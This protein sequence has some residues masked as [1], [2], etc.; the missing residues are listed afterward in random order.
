MRR[1][2]IAELGLGE[3][4]VTGDWK[5]KLLAMAF[6][7]S[8]SAWF[9]KRGYSMMGW[10]VVRRIAGAKGGAADLQVEFFDMFTD[11]PTQNS[12]AVLTSLLVLLEA[13]QGDTR[14]GMGVNAVKIHVDQA[15]CFAG[16]FS[17]AVHVCVVVLP[18]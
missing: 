16:A 15:G 11:N 3:A 4:A 12:F 10:M 5:M 9:G 18:T 8:G 2:E 14:E 1:K 17:R 6:R 13:L 7:E